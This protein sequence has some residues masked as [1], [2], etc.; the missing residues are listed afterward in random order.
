M[1]VDSII[2]LSIDEAGPPGQGVFLFHVMVDGEVVTSN[3]SLSP[4]ESKAVRE[5]SRRYNG[6]FK[7]AFVPRLAAEKLAAIGSELFALWLAGSWEKIRAKVA[8]GSLRLLVIASDLPDVLNLPWELLRPPEGDFLGLDSKFSIRRF[9]RSGEQIQNFGGEL[10]P[11]PLRLL[12]AVS[13]PTD[14]ATLD[15]EREEEY[16]IRAISGLDVAF[17]SGDLGSFRDLRDH[18]EQF[19]PHVVHLNGHGAVLKKCPRCE[20]MNG[21]EEKVCSQCSA[22]LEAV[23]ALG[24]FAFEDESGK[25]DMKSSEE[26]GRLMAASGVCCVFVSGCETGKAPPTEALGGV[27]QGLVGQEVPL[28]IGWAASISDDVANQFARSFYRTLAAGRPIDR[29]LAQ[30]RQDVAKACE[31]RGDPSW[32]LPVLYSATDQGLIF[33]PDPG[34]PKEEPLR[35]IGPQLPLPGMTEGYAEQFVGRRR[36]QQRILAALRDDSLRTVIITGLGGSGKSSLATRLAWKLKG[37]GFTPIAVPSSRDKPLTGDFLLRTLSDAFL[38]ADLDDAFQKLNNPQITADARLRYAVGIL[39]KNRFLLVLDNFESN[40][41]EAKRSII[42]PKL[43]E[44]YEYLL[45]S[46][47]GSSRAIVTSRY[48]PAGKLPPKVRE[49]PLGDFGEA[50]FFKFMRRDDLVEARLRSG[51]L[52]HELMRE[53]YRLFG[54]TPRFLDQIRKVLRD[55]PAD[56]LKKQLERVLVPT[57]LE[58]GELQKILDEY[59]EE[60][61]TSRLYSYLSPESRAALSRAA[62]YGVA[63]NLEGLAAVTGEPTENLR[64]FVWEWQNHA[65]AY[66]DAERVAELWAI[67]GLLRSWLLAQISPEDRKE[68]Q[69]AAGDFLVGVVNED[70]EDELGLSPVEVDLE[71]R[72]QYLH[73]GDYE[74]A[75][76]VTARISVFFRRSGLYDG[77]RRLNEELLR[78]EEHP[79]TMNWI[80]R[81]NLQQANYSEAEIWYYRSLDVKGNS[82]SQEASV[83]FHELGRIDL[84]RGEYGEAQ[85]KFERVLKITQQI[86]DREGEAAAW[87]H[88]ASI[89]L[90][91]GEYEDARQKFEKALKIMQ[92]IGARTGEASTLNQLASID[93][94][95][96]EYEDARQKFEMALK[97]S[98]QIGDRAG[99]ASTWNNLASIDLCR[100]EYEDARQ[101]FETALKISQ[102]IG[103]RAGEAATLHNLASIDLRRG[104]YDEARQKFETALKIKQQIGDRAGEAATFAQL[105][106]MA[107]ERGQIEVGL[108]L[109]ALSAMI[110]GSIGHAQIKEVEPWVNRLASQLNY[111]QEQLEAMHQEVAESRQRDRGAS[112]IDADFAD[113]APG[114]DKV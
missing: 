21:P 8:Q 50:S 73:A 15:Y 105:G 96:G 28:A 1:T 84:C 10:R 41:D 67:Y 46:L 26:L 29:A 64:G 109:V 7:G 53:V 98:Q 31:K 88:L 57:G 90:R 39:N 43:A 56:D 79:S 27:C 37:D 101:K 58:K 104:E 24:F 78:Y 108:R 91:R 11:R 76:E 49:E 74:R 112:L 102:Q 35:Q 38:A 97:I 47:V 51:E 89:D 113:P 99:E 13:S 107:S 22:S 54:G 6:L 106:I 2:T 32:T 45:A 48:I 63:M 44:F 16:L 81:A 77:L 19:Q 34:R 87:H 93:L 18:V 71:A 61:F 75:R 9:P 68:A 3:Q 103:D 62:V 4:E 70:R 30:A 65:F 23:S 5:I 86:E 55:I 110:L 12:M 80:G 59:C 17:N 66:P 94:C 14:L 114:P 85:K 111:T 83:A 42:D 95:R 92:Q 20:G 40:M 36:E 82:V 52:S 72:T 100:G 25:T 69:K 33:D 60:I